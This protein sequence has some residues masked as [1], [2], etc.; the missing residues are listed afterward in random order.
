MTKA[1]RIFE[2]T[3]K[4]CRKHIKTWGYDERIGFNSLCTEEVVYPRT[5]SAVKAILKARKERAVMEAQLTGNKL[6]LQA[7]AMVEATVANAQA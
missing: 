3:F 5:V 6:N 1:E 7:I 4:A 2:E